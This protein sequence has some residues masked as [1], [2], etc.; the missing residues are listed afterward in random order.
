MAHRGLMVDRGGARLGE[1]F[2]AV[3]CAAR[4]IARLIVPVSCPGC[5]MHDVRWC[6]DCASAWWEPPLRSESMAPR[7]DIE[8]RPALPVWAIAEL[9]GTSHAMVVAWKDGG[10]RDLDRFF[11]DAVGRAATQIAPS[12]DEGRIHSRA[13]IAV[14]PVPARAASTRTR[15]IDLPLLLASAAAKG[16]RAGGVDATVRRVLGIG[17]GEQRGASARQRWLQASSLRVTRETGSPATVLLVDDVMTTGATLASAVRSLDVTFL[18]VGAGLCL[19]AAP[20]SSARTR[21]ALS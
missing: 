10:R 18:T 17:K 19:A 21:G 5:G 3:G 12:I 20:P 6:D 15:G 1:P 11:A 2:R 13:P 8:G 16:L 7:L 9:V 14:I 4:D